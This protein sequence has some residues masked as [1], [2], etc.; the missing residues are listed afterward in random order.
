M[1]YIIGESTQ[2]QAAGTQS[3]SG[4]GSSGQCLVGCLGKTKRELQT[5]GTSRLRPEAAAHRV[6]NASRKPKDQ[7]N[8]VDLFQF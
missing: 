6:H 1:L 2:G 3:N 5:F 4:S 8:I 7:V